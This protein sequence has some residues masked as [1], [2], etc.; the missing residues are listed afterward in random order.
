MKSAEEMFEEL[1]YMEVRK[2]Q[3]TISYCLKKG[4]FYYIVFKKNK[5]TVYK[6]KG[7]PGKEVSSSISMKELQAINKQ[8]E[9]LGWDK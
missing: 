8:V 4:Y 5:K 7:V 6:S 1:G 9:E 2:K 3:N